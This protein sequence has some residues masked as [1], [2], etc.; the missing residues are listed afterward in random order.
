MKKGMMLL[1]FADIW[2]TLALGMIGPIYAIFVAEIGGYLVEASWAYFA[3][4][5]ATGLLMYIFGKIEDKIEDKEKMVTLGFFLST[6]GCISYIFVSNFFTLI[7][8]Q[9]ILGLSQSILIPA[10]NAIYSKYLEEGK[11]ASEWGDWE[12]MKHIITAFSAVIGAFIV[13]VFNFQI[14]FIIMALL[15]SVSIII[16]FYTQRRKDLNETF[17]RIIMFSKKI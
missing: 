8:T 7:I 5:F 10:H 16:S 2:V 6:L 12:A 13:G 9:I 17:D 1:L 15:S 11:V 3:M 4:T 14:L